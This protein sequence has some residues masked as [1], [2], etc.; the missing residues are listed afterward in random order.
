[1]QGVE[2]DGDRCDVEPDETPV[3]T[4]DVLKKWQKALLEVPYC[5]TIFL[6]SRS[7][8]SLIGTLPP[9][10]A[11]ITCGLSLRRTHSG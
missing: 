9:R 2:D 3:L 8:I 6:G 1:M 5:E 11:K 10:S 7:L 4:K